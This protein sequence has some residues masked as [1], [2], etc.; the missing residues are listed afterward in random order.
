[1]RDASKKSNEC[2]NKEKS[3][4]FAEDIDWSNIDDSMFDQICQGAQ[5]S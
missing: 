5:V 1:M 4:D 2:A 3:A